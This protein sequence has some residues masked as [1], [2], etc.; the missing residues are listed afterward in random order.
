MKTVLLALCSIALLVTL[1]LFLIEKQ[2]SLGLAS[3]LSEQKLE[4]ISKS[5]IVDQLT[6][7]K[8]ASIQIISNLRSDHKVLQDK[9]NLQI[10]ELSAANDALRL[11]SNLLMQTKSHLKTANDELRALK[12]EL[13]ESARKLQA[14]S[15]SGKIAQLE[16]RIQNLEDTNIKLVS[17]LS[18]K[19]EQSLNA[20]TP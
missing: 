2:M 20:P 14:S 12:A 1:G 19:A 15:Q 18:A 13:V 7:D 10:S 4:L 3:L 9:L 5:E 16:E 17:Q 8:E 11:E 6:L